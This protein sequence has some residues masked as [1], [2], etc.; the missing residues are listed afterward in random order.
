MGVS[1]KQN[2]N[3]SEELEKGRGDFEGVMMLGRTKDET[4]GRK[5]R[6]GNLYNVGGFF[7]PLN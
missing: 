2:T 5:R 4:E 3:F 7:G 6:Y 1:G